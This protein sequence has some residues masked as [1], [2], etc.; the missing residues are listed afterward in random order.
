MS[1]EKQQIVSAQVLLRAASGRPLDRNALITSETLA[2]YAPSANTVATA[3]ETFA[4]MGFTVGYFVGIGF[5][6]T[7]T[8]E[9]FERILQIKLSVVEGGGVEA[10]REDGSASY[11]IP[12]DAIPRP[13]ADLVDA[14]T[15]T[16]P[17]DFGPTNF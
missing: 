6:I 14:V 12:L 9:T 10:V 1:I 11:E 16:P 17:P 5:S 15:F 13:I 7:A 2:D 3:T 4:A 8:I